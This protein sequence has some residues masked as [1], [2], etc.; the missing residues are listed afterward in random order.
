VSIYQYHIIASSSESEYITKKSKFIAFSFHVTSKIEI[1]N[2]LNQ[3]RGQ[4]PKAGHYC[5]AYRLGLNQ[6]D[7]RANDDG[8][9]SGTAGRPILGQIDSKELTN[10]LVIVVRYFGGIKLGASGLISAYKTSA[11]A[12]L[13][14]SEVRIKKV[15]K[16]IHIGSDHAH[17]N[18]LMSHAKKIGFEIDGIFYDPRPKV[19]LKVPLE[20]VEQKV[21][22]LKA[23]TLNMSID[24]A[25][26]TIAKNVFHIFDPD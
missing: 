25:K 21:N 22:L 5:Y 6:N 10:T 3:V 11:K 1:E 12:V 16:E 9:P 18:I 8:E 14:I 20:E 2:C 7:Y 19:V 26:E 23:K 24:Q 4:H 13:D 17:I 15:M